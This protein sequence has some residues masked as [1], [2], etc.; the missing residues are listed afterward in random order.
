M[1]V[2]ICL[3]PG[4]ASDST[5]SGKGPLEYPTE[6]RDSCD[7]VCCGLAA[8]CFRATWEE[9]SQTQLIHFGLCHLLPHCHRRW[10]GTKEAAENSIL[11]SKL[12][13]HEK[14]TSVQSHARLPME[15]PRA[16]ES[17]ASAS[18]FF[19]YLLWQNIPDGTMSPPCT[20]SLLKAFQRLHYPAEEGNTH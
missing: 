2:I 3:R 6:Q 11:R 16:R 12:V 7:S 9:Q 1:R 10:E 8:S 19:T 17:S 13:V 20:W 18:K 4:Q 15:Q 5:M 14:H